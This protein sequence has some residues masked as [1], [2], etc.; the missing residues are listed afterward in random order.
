MQ[1]DTRSTARGRH[2]LAILV[3]LGALGA[4]ALLWFSGPFLGR[5]G[6]LKEARLGELHCLP[7]SDFAAA[8]RIQIETQLKFNAAMLLGQ[9]NQTQ[10]V[11]SGAGLV[12]RLRVH[13]LERRDSG[14]LLALQLDELEGS[15]GAVES[16]PELQKQLSE[17]FFAVLEPGCR[18]RSFGF[19]KGLAPEVVNRLQ[20]LMQGLSVS[21][22]GSLD[23]K[24]WASQ[25]WDGSGLYT[26]SYRRTE[27][28]LSFQK[29]RVSYVQPH[30][31]SFGVD[32]SV[33]I[34]VLESNMQA[35]LDADHAWLDTLEDRE[36]LQV[37]TTKKGSFIADLIVT[38]KLK[39]SE[40][41]GGAAQL[42]ASK[43]ELSWR[44][45]NA[46]PIATE[47]REPEPPA[48][49]KGL[50]L[51]QALGQFAE[52]YRS[53]QGLRAIDFLKLYLR[54]RPE[55]AAALVEMAK[56]R[57]IP[58]ELEPAVFHALERA[59]T[60]EAHVALLSALSDEH[61]TDNRARA[62]AALPDIAK[63][64]RRTLDGLREMARVGKGE[65]RS[66]TDLV[67]NAGTYA[68]G[69]LE[70][71][72]RVKDP[73]LARETRAEIRGSLQR[74]NSVEGRAA[75]L[76]AIGNSGNPEFIPDVKPLFK[77]ESTVLRSHAVQ[78]LEHMKPEATQGLFKE[79]IEAEQDPQVRGAIA[80]TFADQARRANTVAPTPVLDGAMDRLQREPDVRVRALLIDLIGPACKGSEAAMQSLVGQFNRESEPQ[81]L[82][83]IGKYVPA[84]KLGA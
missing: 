29:Q 22:S 36:R 43:G 13:A 1:Q 35:S 62:A 23:A 54:A 63:P 74:T 70:S 81:M 65:N 68:L 49:M 71:R 12:G 3:V 56:R 39:R 80:A 8:Y 64:D 50:P 48:G 25:E 45:E 18:L 24:A 78:S 76:D 69:R 67:R 9:T 4:L 40:D 6:Q 31:S 34:R 66:E 58:A 75:L 26:A 82:K 42:V 53:G 37:L 47:A 15:A 72:V 38:I 7:D 60:P 77:A 14:M 33:D 28:P 84:G 57:E 21:L 46:A 61:T 19:A 2:R 17:P 30:A 27:R 79:L 44:E 20:G 52:L 11:K 16:A 41:D 5:E 73:E 10:L 32:D 83:L 59:N 55:M 51:D